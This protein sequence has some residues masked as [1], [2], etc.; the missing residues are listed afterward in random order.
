MKKLP[1]YLSHF[2]DEVKQFRAGKQLLATVPALLLGSAIATNAQLLSYESF[3]GYAVGLQVTA[4]TPSPVVG[5]YTG[6]WTAVDFGDQRPSV[7]SGALSYGGVGYAA[8][9]G[10]HIGVPNNLSGGEINAGNSGRMFRVL[11]SALT[12]NNN[13]ASAVYL[14]WLFQSGQE[15]GASTYQMLELYNGNTA[16]A[17]RAFAMGLVGGS[18]YNFQA[19]DANS[20]IGTGVS[21]DAGVHLFVVKFDLSASANSDSVT[22]WVDPTLGAGEPAGGVVVSAQDFAFDRLAFSDY[23]GNSANWGEI[24]WGTTFDSVTVS[25]PPVSPTIVAVANP[26]GASLNQSFKATA[27]VT[28]GSGAITNVSIDLSSIGLSTASLVLSN[29]NVYTNTF[30][31]PGVATIG[32]A[33]FV[34]LAIDTTPLSATANIAFTVLPNTRQW[35]GGSATDN[36]WSSI[37][38]WL[39]NVPPSLPVDSVTFA[40]SA[41]LTPDM[42]ANYSIAGLTFGASAG[43]FKIGTTT[44][45]VLTNGL[46]GIVNQSANP[47]VLNVPVVMAA[48][49][50][51]DTAAGN[52]VLSNTVNGA[53]NLTKSGAGTL[54]FAGA[55]DSVIGNFIVTNGL[56]RVEAGSVSVSAVAGNS[57]VDMGAT[58]EVS[59]GTLTIANGSGAWY[60]IGDTAATTSTLTISGGTMIVT[61]NY[62][63]QV[64]HNASGVLNVNSGNFIVQDIGNLGVSFAEL[65][66]AEG[67]VNLNGG[68][69]QVVRFRGN[70]GPSLGTGSLYF[71]GGTLKPT[72]STTIFIPA[73]PNIVTA[74]RNGGAI[75]DTTGFNVSIA[76]AL[77]HSPVGGDNEID[78]GLTKL[79]AGTLTLSGGFGYTGPTKVL[80]GALSVDSSLGVPA[81]AS[82]LVVSNAAVVFDLS[83]G[84]PLP[85]SNVVVQ[86]SSTLSLTL[87]QGASAING[88]GSLTLGGENVINLNYGVLAGNPTASAFNVAGGLTASGTNLINI[89]A[90]GNLSVG[91]FPLIDYTGASVPTNNFRL[92]ALPPG[93]NAI[94]T[95]NAANTSLD[96]LITFM[97]NTLTWH[98]ASADNSVLLT[99]WDI[100]VSSNWYDLAQNPTVY[101]QYSGN[102]IGDIVTFGDFG[103]NLDG[104]NMVNLPGR[105]LPS[106]VTIDSGSDYRLT[107]PGGIDGATGLVK[108]SGGV[109]QIGTSNS[110]TG[111]VTINAG[112]LAIVNPSALGASA[113]LVTLAGGTLHIG[114]N[115]TNANP[116]RL[117]SSS[118]LEAP[119]GVSAQLSGSVTGAV[120]L[121]ASGAGSLTLAGNVAVA[122]LTKFDEGALT[123][124]GSNTING[125]VTL[126]AGTLR[127]SGGATAIPGG[128]NPNFQIG[129]VGTTAKV[130][131]SGS[132]RLTSPSTGRFLRLG[133][134]GGV[135]VLDNGPTGLMLFNSFGIGFGNSGDSSAG[136]IYNS[137]T[138]T[139]F[140]G[141]YLG[142]T[143]NAYGYFRNSGVTHWGD[144]LFLALNDSA[145]V[146]GAVGVVDIVGGTVIKT[147][148]GATWLNGVNRNYSAAPS[149]AALNITGGSLTFTGAGYQWN[150]NNG[151]NNYAA[152]NITGSGVLALP[153]AGGFGLGRNNNAANRETFTLANGGTL[154]A[155]YSFTTA[156]ASSPV[157][158]FNN[159]TYRA[160]GDSTGPIQSGILAYVQAG[161]AFF[162]TAGF[163]FS[164]GVPLLTPTGNGVTSITIGGTTS[165]YIGAP[166]VMITGD[167]V[168]AAAIANFDPTTGTIT[169]ITVTSPGSGY[170]TATVTLLGG[171]GTPGSGA[172]PGAATATAVLG[173][174]TSGGLTKTGNGTL[175]LN[176]VNTYTGPTVVQAGTL[177]GTGTIA[178]ALT[179]SANAILAPGSGASGTLTIN[180][181]L[182]LNPGS[183]NIFAVNGSTLAKTDI[184]VG[185]G[186]TYGGTL[187]IVPSGT[188]TAG[189]QFVLFSGAGATNASNFAN[190]IVNPAANLECSFTNGVLTVVSAMATTP[191]NI[192]YS[193][194]GGN[195][196]LSWPTTH[197]GWILQGQ[198]NGL[199]VG[200][201][202][203]WVDIPGSS[204]LTATNISVNPAAPAVFYRLRKP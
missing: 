34:V 143:E 33:N 164:L 62:G 119:L 24:R 105:V 45:G 15:T 160:A 83:S 201:G 44:G 152:V 55:G 134:Q 113:N 131:V 182:T 22:V 58:L 56:T 59:G 181:Q 183:T 1:K 10:N 81:V 165:G 43:S 86:G 118:T 84:I 202:A 93:V 179:N 168:G 48:A 65:S 49:Q 66:G 138:F 67:T 68:V 91:S 185:A 82:D 9:N 189:Q 107:G 180:G 161:G 42:D 121:T 12:V 94:L 28:P 40:G 144:N 78:G 127:I 77:E 162:D 170:T 31:I 120:S 163:N 188:F 76:D 2:F 72:L 13:S 27:T 26:V 32:A 114:A 98:G 111:G 71:N 54:S 192:T 145:S 97:G 53:F 51:F 80:G 186:V 95:N 87:N 132:G 50:T 115:L 204:G 155:T 6:N 199:G 197:L 122:G 102:S 129:S 116:V 176:A 8:G 96:L 99:N 73:M 39:G 85:A 90:S 203:N 23:E 184:A 153:N 151:V 70:G 52:L 4:V 148:T 106:S 110:F 147:G 141:S 37:A 101:N 200:L 100:N 126:N 135:G 193:V 46:G 7:N 157:F 136:V 75:V 191:T 112:T 47:Q 123:L 172:T 125:N 154:V 89:L 103:F 29:A 139:N 35:T 92:G 194:S 140:S 133:T 61:N 149:A 159:G 146:N 104:T 171:S 117:T 178:G 124:V 38:N 11:D 142:N 174:V 30:T 19:N 167:G 14:S 3:G 69:M 25:N 64:G 177:S 5:G 18:E 166:V 198:T 74:V 195:L 21:A 169:G 16:D 187:S 36:K 109:F 173:A 175:S 130:E 41:R 156:A 88:T 137:G 150:I 190:L 60:P 196:S 79:G 63:I 158:T 17:S 108:N 128:G 20:S 57:K